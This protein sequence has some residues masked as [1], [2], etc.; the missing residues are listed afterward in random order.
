MGFDIG[1]AGSVQ[2]YPPFLGFSNV[3]E[4]VGSEFANLDNE[5]IVILKKMSKKDCQ[6]REKVGVSPYS[7]HF[8]LSRP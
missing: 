4:S 8:S 2:V 6:T 5:V 1:M 3:F 7:I